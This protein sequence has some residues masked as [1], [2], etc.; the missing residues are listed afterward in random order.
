[1][2]QNRNFNKIFKNII[3]NLD[4][5]KGK[6]KL[7]LHV[8]CGPCS[9]IPLERLKDYFDITLLF[10]N[11]NIY[12]KEEHDRRYQELN[13]YID[14]T[15]YGYPIIY[16]D[17]DYDN[18]I[19]DLKLYADMIFYKRIFRRNAYRDAFLLYLRLISEAIILKLKMLR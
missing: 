6:P 16:I 18:Y 8:C 17:Y 7:L 4:I 5:S 10:N 12:P 2:Q 19:A 11:S 9:T 13:R 3:Q 14:E 15:G 1:M